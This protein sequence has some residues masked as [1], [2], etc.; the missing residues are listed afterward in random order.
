MC[1]AEHHDTKVHSE[2]KHLEELWL[3]EGQD[4]DTTQL[5]QGDTT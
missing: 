4:D 1:G 2:V 3:G 5:R